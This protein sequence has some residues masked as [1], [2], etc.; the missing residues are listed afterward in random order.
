M[1]IRIPCLAGRQTHASLSPRHVAV[2]DMAGVELPLEL[3]M[4]NMPP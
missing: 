1:A 3:G 2:V 4:R